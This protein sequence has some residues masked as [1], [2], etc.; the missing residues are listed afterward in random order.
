MATLDQAKQEVRAF[1]LRF[2]KNNDLND[3]DDIFALGFVN[4]LFALQ[5]VMFV[6][7]NFS[8]SVED[9]DLQLDNFSSVNA[10][11]ALV[12]R[13]TSHGG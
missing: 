7:K 12:G 13:K 11:A 3:N 4:S 1:M 10:I 8:V 2:F 9:E 6:E 5:L